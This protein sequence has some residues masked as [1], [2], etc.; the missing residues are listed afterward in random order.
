MAKLL[1]FLDSYYA[2]DDWDEVRRRI[3]EKE[4]GN[5]DYFW[6][7]FPASPDTLPK[8]FEKQ[9]FDLAKYAWFKNVTWNIEYYGSKSTHLHCHMI[10]EQPKSQLR[11]A[12]VIEQISKSMSIPTNMVHC[13]RDKHSFTNRLNYVKGIKVSPEKQDLVEKDEIFR[14]NNN[15]DVYYKHAI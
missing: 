7:Q 9:I 3:V 15:L 10:V 6:I 14:K 12:R 1:D 11:P 5:T 2:Y 4:K 13:K 8:V